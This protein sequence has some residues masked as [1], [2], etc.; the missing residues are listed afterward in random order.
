MISISARKCACARG[1]IF[2]KAGGSR[3][4]P[5]VLTNSRP[6]RSPMVFA[7]G[8]FSLL[9]GDCGGGLA[10]YVEHGARLG[11]HWNVA[12]LHLDGRGAHALRGE[13]FQLR[14]DTAILGGH[15]RPARLRPPSDAIQ[16][17]LG[18][19][20]ESWREVGRIDDALLFRRQIAGEAWD[21]IR[22]HPDAA[23][24]DFNLLA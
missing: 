21:A 5:A 8:R 23:V 7:S 24:G 14:M 11:E 2:R 19:E 22:L 17:L 3:S 6:H 20:I 13:A 1:S 16:L 9:C 15:D 18:E 12:A 4:V 10:D